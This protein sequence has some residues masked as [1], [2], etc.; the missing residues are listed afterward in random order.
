[1]PKSPLRIVI[2]PKPVKITVPRGN[3]SEKALLAV[4]YDTGIYL[5]NYLVSPEEI[6]FYTL[7]CQVDLTAYTLRDYGLNHSI[8]NLPIKVTVG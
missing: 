4:L 5:T 7:P 2:Y 3:W 1:M 6:T 8:G